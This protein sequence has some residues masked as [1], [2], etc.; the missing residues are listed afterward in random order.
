MDLNPEIELARQCIENTGSHLFLTG[1]AG[2]GKT[3]F[4]RKLKDKSPK[5]MIVVAPTGIAA[6][7][8]GGVTIHSFFQLPFAPYIPESKFTSAQS[9]HKFGREKISIICSM[10]LLVIDEISMV[11]ADLLDAI[12]AVLRRYRDKHKP[13]GGVQ[14]LMIGDLQQLAPVVKESDLTLLSPYYNTM[15]FFGSHALKETN[16]ITIQLQKVYRQSD[17]VFISLLNKIRTN[18]FDHAVLAELNKRYIPGFKPDEDEGYIRLTTHNHQAQRINEHQLALLSGKSY[19]FKATVEGNF[20][21]AAYPA[22]VDLYLKRGAQIMFLKNDSS[23]EKRFYNGKIGI[24]T[25]VSQNNISVWGKGDER[26]FV[27]EQ[28]EWT[29]SK[30]TLNAETKEI[31]EDIEG[32]FRQYPIRLAWAIT[33]HK[34]QGLTFDRAIIDA[35]TSFAH[36]QVYVALSR[37]KTL[38]GMVL[39]SPLTRESVINDESISAFTR[40]V[41]NSPPDKNRLNELQRQYYYELLCELF[42][43]AHIKKYFSQSLRLLDEF[44]YDLYPKTL[45]VYKNSFLRFQEEI[46]KVALSFQARYAQLMLNPNY[47]KDPVLNERLTSGARYFGEKTAEILQEPILR[48]RVEVDSKELKKRFDEAFFTLKELVQVK[49]DTLA[50]TAIHGFTVHGYL[51]NKAHILVTLSN[52]QPAKK[53]EAEADPAPKAKDIREMIRKYNAGEPLKAGELKVVLAYMGNKETS[54]PE[55]TF[56]PAKSA[57]AGKMEKIDISSDIDHPELYQVLI[58]WRNALAANANLP[59]YAILRQKAILGVTNTLP[60][61]IGELGRIP[62]IGRR[63]LDKYG[64]EIISMVK[65][66]TATRAGKRRPG[67]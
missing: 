67:S 11:R 1:K 5:R 48:T 27:L 54:K 20:P 39:S 13:F 58:G 30:Y 64:D 45:N 17:D 24:V 65:A 62:F 56:K 21:E 32:K 35:H 41:E 33:I 61:T 12:D 42:G 60:E 2:T 55:K 18:E 31:T 66:Y 16:Y 46:E 28:E 23:T 7:N 44:F 6:I 19:C 51:K 40:T 15:F 43:F 52:P 4:L 29:N 53:R 37:C 3:T 47:E 26:D 36:G 38:E 50:H 57:K 25:S 9:S 63:I 14:L 49:L 59:V 34:S 8:A 10:D 22:D